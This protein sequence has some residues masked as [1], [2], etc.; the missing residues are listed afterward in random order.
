M[1]NPR[2]TGYKALGQVITPGQPFPN[3]TVSAKGAFNATM[4]DTPGGNPGV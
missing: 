3:R 2:V 1:T 4:P